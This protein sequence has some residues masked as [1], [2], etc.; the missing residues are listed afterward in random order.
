[1]SIYRIVRYHSIGRSQNSLLVERRTRDRTV[2]SSNSG[3]SGGKSF[4]LQS[5]LCVLPL[6]RCPLHP[7]F[8][9]VTRK[10]PRP[11]CRNCGWQV[12]PTHA[13]TLDPTKSEWADY[14]AIQALCGNLLG[15]K[16]TRNSSGN[17]RSQSSKLAEPLRTDP[18]LKCARAN[19]HFS[20]FWQFCFM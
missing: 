8:T 20:V 2:A 13:Y 7:R 5:R 16:L 12:T 19:L 17:T 3:R 14:A 1:M 10:R 4:F 18:G 9:S 6:I 11:V 15:N